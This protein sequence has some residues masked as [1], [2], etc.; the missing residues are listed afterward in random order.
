MD[1]LDKILSEDFN[2]SYY[3][4]NEEYDTMY[5]GLMNKEINYKSLLK[6]D[7]QARERLSIIFEDYSNDV[8]PLIK[9]AE[10]EGFKLGLRCGIEIYK[11]SKI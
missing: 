1:L 5:V 7:S 8:D 3:F 11:S 6:D 2:L 9:R 4:R 10:I